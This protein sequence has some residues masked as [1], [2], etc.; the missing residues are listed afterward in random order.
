MGTPGAGE[1]PLSVSNEVAPVLLRTNAHDRDQTVLR[2]RLCKILVRTMHHV[3][4]LVLAVFIE[5]Q[6]RPTRSHDCG[7][8]AV[9]CG[10]CCAGGYQAREADVE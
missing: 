4:D 8:T 9:S 3:T 6:S 7:I 1:S 10:L 2:H 5:E